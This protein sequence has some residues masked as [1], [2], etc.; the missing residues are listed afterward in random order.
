MGDKAGNALNSRGTFRSPFLS[1]SIPE[2]RS[3]EE[4]TIID[5]R[6]GN[7]AN[8]QASSSGA[9]IRGEGACL[10]FCCAAI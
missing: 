4:D 5:I 9:G 7:G 1:V 10:A 8:H 6:G 3:D 2:D